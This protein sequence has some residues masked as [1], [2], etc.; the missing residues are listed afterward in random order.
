MTALAKSVTLPI[1][2]ETVA[3]CSGAWSSMLEPHPLAGE[4]RL[5]SVP[6]TVLLEA[7]P[8]R[9]SNVSALCRWLR[10]RAL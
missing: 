7:A 2:C 8:R 1:A 3:A 9:L 10:T 4:L 6:Q 5:G